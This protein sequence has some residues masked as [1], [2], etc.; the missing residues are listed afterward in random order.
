[1]LEKFGKP[2]ADIASIKDFLVTENDALVEG[3][4]GIN[5][6]YKRQEKRKSCM[7]CNSKIEKIDFYKQ[8]IPY[9]IC[10]NCGHLNGLFKDSDEFCEIAYQGVGA[11][12]FKKTYQESDFIRFN[13]RVKTVY[14]PKAKFL[15]DSLKNDH[16]SKN[17]SF[18]F[19]DVGAGLGYFLSALDIEGEKNISGYEVSI[20]S[21]NFANSAL[22]KDIVKYYDIKNTLKT[23]NSIDSEVVSMIGVLEHL[24][25]PFEVLQSISNNNSV[26]YL[27]LS[28][29]TFGPSVFFEILS[30][31]TYHRQLSRDHT[32]L[33][34]NE[35]IDWICNEIGFERVSE[36]WFGQDTLDLY[37]HTLVHAIKENK[38]SEFGAKKFKE[39]FWQ[40]IDPMQLALD[41]NK[42][43]SEIHILLK[44]N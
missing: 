31:N 21:V 33:Y 41:K 18:S 8:D 39:M 3:D 13:E 37:R 34:T 10:T 43:S 30:P 12:D 7:N 22:K 15:I 19:C 2:F 24:Q 44:K 28:I 38:L 9:S 32:H 16:D 4:K 11:E 26:E 29:P 1:M 14:Q 5:A 35:S 42:L 25:S 23:I 27:F 17:L 6:A 36:W 20:D 40:A